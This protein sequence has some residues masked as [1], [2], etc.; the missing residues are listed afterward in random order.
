MKKLTKSK[1]VVLI[2]ISVIVLI[3]IGYFVSIPISNNIEHDK[4]VALD[5]NQR[6]L[7][8]KLVAASKGTDTWTYSA[9]CKQIYAGAVP[10]GTYDCS[11]VISTTKQVTAAAEVNDLH[12]KYFSVID[13]YSGLTQKTPLKLMS[14]E[15]FGKKLVV[16]GAEKNYADNKS[17]VDCWYMIS[18]GQTNSTL[19][20]SIGGTNI[21]N[22][23][24]ILRV[25]L[26]CKDTSNN[27]W[28]LVVK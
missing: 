11:T 12:T 21:V 15:S 7:Y 13:S 19:Q 8:E 6:D 18:L 23:T 17:S 2:I 20:N 9:N 28:Y 5:N 16:S 26:T 1:R 4:F 22:D 24:G 3:I 10:T 25:N 27:A 14:P